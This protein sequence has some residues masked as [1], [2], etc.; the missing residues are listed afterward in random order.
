M[1]FNRSVLVVDEEHSVSY[2]R[3]EDEKPID[4]IIIKI[5]D[6]ESQASIPDIFDR[7]DE[8]RKIIDEKLVD[9]HSSVRP[10]MRATGMC[11]LGSLVCLIIEA[12]SPCCDSQVEH[13]IILAIYSIVTLLFLKTFI[14]SYQPNSM[15]YRTCLS[16]SYTQSSEGFNGIRYQPQVDLADDLTENEEKIVANTI[17]EYKKFA[18][19]NNLDD[20]INTP[21]IKENYSKVYEELTASFL[22]KKPF[23]KRV[24]KT[25]D[26]FLQAID[27][28]G[29]FARTPPAP[30]VNII[31]EYL[32]CP[33]KEDLLKE[34]RYKK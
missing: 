3:L 6:D 8:S 18:K 17:S 19:L 22:Q 25:G 28:F 12:T 1:G 31:L 21:V 2:A 26:S 24:K 32:G 33:N 10:C 23:K 7:L 14:D 13:D 16:V 5:N 15:L 20:K 30:V 9:T 27:T 11:S 4:D 34:H 29:L